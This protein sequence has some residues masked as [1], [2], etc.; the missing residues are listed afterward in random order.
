MKA[1]DMRMVDLILKKKYGGELTKEEIRFIIQG[2]TGGTI[3]DYQIASWLMAIYFKGMTAVETA[4]LTLSMVASGDTVDLSEIKGIKVDKHSTGGVGDTTS[5]ML[6]PLV[7]CTGIPMAKMTGRGL[8]HTGGTVD[9]LES[10]PGFNT[11]LDTDQFIR[12]VQ[13]VGAAIIGQTKSLVPADGKLYALRDVTGTVDSIPLIASSIMSKKIASGSDAI[14]LDVKTGNGAFMK[15]LDDSFALAQA[16]VDIGTNVGK[17]VVALVTDMGQPLGMS[18]GNALEVV[19][20]IRVL[21]GEIKGPLR[22]VVLT[23]GSYLVTLADKAK[24]IAEAKKLLE[25]FID[26]GK[27]IEKFREIIEIS[28][29]ERQGC[30]RY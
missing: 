18:V 21:K 4:E 19:E 29:R 24:D 6:V 28:G 8:G 26:N 20:A 25:S 7:A 15:S 3:P 14:V 16:M 9:K 27:A 13:K 17:R 23:I 10:I 30:R 12:A 22:D 1:A 11:K 2:Y 5:L